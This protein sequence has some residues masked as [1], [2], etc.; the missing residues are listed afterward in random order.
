MDYK[1]LPQYQR[2]YQGL[3]S[4]KRMQSIAQDKRPV[5]SPIVGIPII[6][7]DGSR[8][9]IAVPRRLFEAG[10]VHAEG[11]RWDH[12]NQRL[13][14]NGGKRSCYRLITQGQYDVRL[15]LWQWAK[16]QRKHV[17]SKRLTPA[18]RKALNIDK[19][20]AK[21]ERKLAKLHCSP[22][23]NPV[24]QAPREFHGDYHRDSELHWAQGRAMRI[25]LS[26]H[27]TAPAIRAYKHIHRPDW[28]ALYAAATSITGH[29]IP[30]DCKHSRVTKLTRGP[31]VDEYIR[32]PDQHLARQSKPYRDRERQ[33]DTAEMM[34]SRMRYIEALSEKRGMQSQIKNLKECKKNLLTLG[35]E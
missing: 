14:L 28:K 6:L 20:I 1:L 33:Y 12:N 18:D 25:K 22:P 32:R 2:N 30:D 26:K 17:V 9:C 7:D 5:R 16:A 27:F 19:D 29:G 11:V 21:T 13:V 24:C 34:Q 23:V 3:L 10:M 31:S 15:L 8:S 4:L 35:V